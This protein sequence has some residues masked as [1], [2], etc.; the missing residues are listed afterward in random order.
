MEGELITAMAG[1]IIALLGLVGVM[2]RRERN[3]KANNPGNPG[4]LDHHDC[5]A[6]DLAPALQRIE[7]KL[8]HE[9]TR[10]RTIL[11]ERLP[12]GGGTL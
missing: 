11:E 7:Q 4:P 2:W 5:Q 12:R 3:G 6:E 8:D 10:I 9:L 1:I